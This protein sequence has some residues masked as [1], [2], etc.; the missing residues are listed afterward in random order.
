LAAY[1]IAFLT[2]SPFFVA[3]D[4]A[5]H[6]LP[7][8]PAV[9]TMRAAPFIAKAMWLGLGPLGIATT[10]LLLRRP[11]A[12]LALCVIFSAISAVGG[13]LLWQQVRPFALLILLVACILAAVGAWRARSNNS[14]KPKPLR[15]S[16]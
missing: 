12:G 16:A 11:M 7:T 6:F 13:F 9:Q 14:F 10:F 2:I 15:G 8:F 3:L 5:L 4:L 1:I